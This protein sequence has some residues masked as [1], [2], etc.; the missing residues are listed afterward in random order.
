MQSAEETRALIRQLT[1]AGFRPISKYKYI[2][3]QLSK[4]YH[5]S[6]WMD[7]QENSIAFQVMKSFIEVINSGVRLVLGIF[8]KNA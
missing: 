5:L 3:P 7:L 2:V 1:T 4:C 6:C 8:G